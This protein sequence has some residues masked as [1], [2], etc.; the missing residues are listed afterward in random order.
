[1]E[2]DLTIRGQLQKKLYE[3]G[4]DPENASEV[5]D[6]MEINMPEMKGRWTEGFDYYPEPMRPVL[7]WT[8]KSY[9]LKWVDVNLPKAFYR[10]LLI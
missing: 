9:A 1:M 3:L 7:L 10:Q 4:M 8:A 2:F 5:L 6:D